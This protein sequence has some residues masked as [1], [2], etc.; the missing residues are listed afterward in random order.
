MSI[1][2]TPTARKNCAQCNNPY[3]VTQEDL[4]LLQKLSPMIAR[5][6]I[7][8]PAP[9]QCPDCRQRRR[10]CMVN[11]MNLYHR[12]CDM[13][14]Q[15]II[16]NVAP[17]SPFRIYNQADWWGNKKW[18]ATEFGR[19]FDFDRPFF[20]QMEEL[21]RDVPHPSLVNDYLLNENSEFTN[22]TGYLK[23]CYLLFH[24]DY[25]E[26]CYYGYG[27]KKCKNCV[28]CTR[29]LE[30]ELCHE[31]VDCT[32]CYNLRDS[33]DC[34]NCHDSFFL[35]DCIGCKNCIGC[36]GLRTKEYHVD[37]TSYTKEAYEK[38]FKQS[39]LDRASG[40]SA[41]REHS[42]VQYLAVP[43]KAL[44][45][46]G[47]TD[48]LGD[49]LINCKDVV[50]SY[51]C[52]D[53]EDARYCHQVSLNAK[54]CMDMYQYGLNAEFVYESCLTGS[55]VYGIRFSSS[56]S[57]GCS[58]I[59]YSIYCH[60]ASQHLFGCFGVNG[61]KYCI[62]NKPYTKEE[63]EEL[64]PRIIEH[65]RTTG[66]WGE[67]FPINL[68][69]FGYNETRA[70][71]FFPMTAES[72]RANG[73]KWLD[74][75]DNASERYLGPQTSLPDAIGDATEAITKNILVCE[76]TG[77]PYK[78]IPQEWTFYRNQG[79]PLPRLCPDE[80]HKR[81]MQLRNPRHLWKRQCQKCQRDIET[82]Y[83][84]E[85]PEIVYCEECYL[86]SVY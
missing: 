69:P 41:L 14:G 13:T 24:A 60:S 62:L 51:E 21:I 38:I 80:R 68:S 5:Q 73:W 6:R 84:P 27:I 12:K 55:T 65:M 30:C 81:R 3:D 49:Y 26:D 4:D 64:M 18:D 34:E 7:D 50:F 37:N 83:A 61:K 44:R 1:S 15:Q 10:L 46:S 16:S 82:T 72:V 54:S 59:L 77:K 74:E 36:T 53:V 71:E 67:Y 20:D 43:K 56:I 39:G 8:L 86:A 76:A 48:C 85:R 32:R 63:Y 23:N 66:E 19:T 28:D 35:N 57:N 45:M 78:I 40:V 2:T 79:I 11:E 25:G 22:Y 47:C 75:K 52:S 17:S 58:E 31:C 33:R 42:R 29:I 70:Q 9:T